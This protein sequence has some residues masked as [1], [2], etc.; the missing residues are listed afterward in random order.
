MAK[1]ALV[2]ELVDGFDDWP[3]QPRLEEPAS[4]GSC[5]G[6]ARMTSELY[7]YDALF[8]PIRVNRLTL[9]N[10]IVMAPMGNIDM[11]EETGRPN[12]KML[13]YFF[14][15]AK[16]GCGLIT[17]GLVPVSHGIDATVTEP[18][19][20]TYFPRIDRSRT[21]MAGWRDLAQGVHAFGSRIFVQLTAG[22][23]RVGNP[24]CL[25]T[26]KRFPASA[27]LLPNY[28][29]PSVPCM[30]LS[31]RRLGHIVRALGQAAADASAMGLDG[32]YLHGHEGYLLE[33]MAN[34]AFNHR[35]LGRYANWRRFG[36]DAVREIRRR[37]GPDLPIMYRIDLSLALE[38]TYGEKVLDGTYLG[39]MR[40]GRSV[41]QTLG[42]MEELVAAGPAG[43]A[44]ALVAA[45][46]G[47]E[48]TLMDAADELGGKLLCAGAARMKFDV[49]NYR[50]Y[51]VGQVRAAEREGGLAVE[52]GHRAGAGELAAGCFD[53]IVCA[54][55]A[56]DAVP[57]IPGVDELLASGWARQASELMRDPAAL[58]GAR[59]VVVVGGGAVGCECAQWLSVECGVERV[60]VVEALPHM[61]EGACTANRGHLLHVLARRGVRLL[62][63]ARVEEVRLEDA[64][65]PGGAIALRVSRNHDRHVPDPY[66]SWTPVLPKNVVNP[67]EPRI[68]DDWREEG[69]RCDLLVLACGGRADDGLFFELQKAHAAPELRNLGDAFAPGRVLEAVRAAYRLGCAL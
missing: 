42:Y 58:A 21:V 31:D 43:M 47:H 13:D 46:R 50:S 29:M 45:R 69:L 41:E 15:R 66:V 34:P 4:A 33:Q 62:N 57:P 67:L 37:V 6:A 68:G 19:G 60:C 26:L 17:T 22:L 14:A 63:M 11:C 35:R 64:E 8:S 12:Q 9:K 7:P 59:S 38:E 20:L 49:E 28:Y 27:S 36:L 24:Q 53:A 3:A 2:Q 65:A 54:T 40:G 56:A 44:C 61:M 23:G 52:L 5:G 48:V 39:R 55:G 1:D 16:G 30:R 10:R 32:V 51:L 25:L 18:G